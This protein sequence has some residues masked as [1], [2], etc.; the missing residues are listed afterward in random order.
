MSNHTSHERR[1]AVRDASYKGHLM[2]HWQEV[3]RATI[4][5]PNLAGVSVS[6]TE[7]RKH[8][9]SVPKV[10]YCGR[11]GRSVV[12]VGFDLHGEA[13][14]FECDAPPIRLG[15]GVEG[16]RKLGVI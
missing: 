6:L 2:S 12:S 9:D 13:L 8:L 4:P 5:P 11:C 15:V 7:F 14:E 1:L 16:L 10:T 3:G